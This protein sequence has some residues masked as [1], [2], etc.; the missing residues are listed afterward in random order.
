MDTYNY[1]CIYT[2]YTY[3]YTSNYTFMKNYVIRLS[4]RVF[5]LEY[6]QL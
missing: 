4:I 2:E 6:T 3:F 5:I 1:M